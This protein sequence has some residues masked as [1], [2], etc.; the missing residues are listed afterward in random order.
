MRDRGFEGLDERGRAQLEAVL[1]AEHMQF[2]ALEAWCAKHNRMPAEKAEDDEERRLA[3]FIANRERK[4]R[5]SWFNAPA[6]FDQLRQKYAQSSAARRDAQNR[7]AE[8]QRL[9]EQRRALLESEFAAEEEADKEEKEEAADEGEGSEDVMAGDCI[10]E[11]WRG[12][13]SQEMFER[14]PRADRELAGPVKGAL[15]HALISHVDAPEKRGAALGLDVFAAL[16]ADAR[17]RAALRR[18]A[19][20]DGG[21]AGGRGR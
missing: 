10:A 20:A 6:S 15:V 18:A 4:G 12:E 2:R 5:A 13:V 7:E 19:E 1:D 17:V 9:E 11:E 3:N 16:A 14:F 8:A 21:T